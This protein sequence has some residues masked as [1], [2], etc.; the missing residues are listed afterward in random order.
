M[1]L[2]FMEPEVLLEP[3]IRPHPEPG[4]YSPSPHNLFHWDPF[5]FRFA[6]YGSV[7]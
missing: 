3:T 6:M 4:Q 2:S 5:E 7:S 1:I